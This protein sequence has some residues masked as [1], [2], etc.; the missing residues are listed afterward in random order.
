LLKNHFHLAVRVKAEEEIREKETL[1][2]SS[3][4][5]YRAKPGS[6]EIREEDQ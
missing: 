1:K 6:I 5:K 4:N 2:V 3:S